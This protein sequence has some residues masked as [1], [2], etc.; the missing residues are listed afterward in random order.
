MNRYA[1]DK[2]MQLLFQLMD[3]WSCDRASRDYRQK[4]PEDLLNDNENGET[5]NGQIWFSAECLAS[6]S[7]IMDHEEESNM[8]RP[9]AKV[10]TNH[11]DQ[12]RILL[13]QASSTVQ[14]K[15]AFYLDLI[16]R[17]EHFDR[18]FTAFEFE[19]VKAMLPIKTVDDIERQQDLTVLFSEALAKAIRR[20]LIRQSHVDECNPSVMIS[21]PRL[22]IVHGLVYC[23]NSSTILKR[24]KHQL[25]TVLRAYHNLLHRIRHM[26]MS[27]SPAQVLLLERMLANEENVDNVDFSQFEKSSGLKDKSVALK[28]DVE[29]LETNRIVGNPLLTNDRVRSDVNRR[30]SAPNSFENDH[31]VTVDENRDCDEVDVSFWRRKKYKLKN[32]QSSDCLVSKEFDE[33]NQATP[34]SYRQMNESPTTDRHSETQTTR[35]VEMQ[36][37]QS[38]YGRVYEDGDHFADDED[39]DEYEQDSILSEDEDEDDDEFG[40]DEGL[41][42]S[43]NHFDH[44]KSIENEAR[45]DAAKIKTKVEPIVPEKFSVTISNILPAAVSKQLLHKLFVSIASIADQLQS[46]YASDLRA[47]L[48]TVFELHS[49]ATSDETDSFSVEEAVEAVEDLTLRPIVP[50]P[51]PIRE[52][53]PSTSNEANDYGDLLSNNEHMQLLFTTTLNAL[54]NIQPAIGCDQASDSS[55]PVESKR[56]FSRDGEFRDESIERTLMT[57][58]L[59]HHS[60]ARHSLNH[61]STSLSNDVSWPRANIETNRPTINLTSELS[62]SP[63]TQ[64]TQSPTQLP[65]QPPTQP[66]QRLFDAEERS[67]AANLPPIWVPDELVSECSGC[68]IQFTLLRRRHHCRNCGFIFCNNCS[69]HFVHLSHF[70][71][72]KPVRVCNECYES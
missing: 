1:Q 58:H 31:A 43:S 10:L 14:N 38:Y 25:P 29:P 30:H 5:F 16:A 69:N 49:S 39:S 36:S 17:L 44:S 28:C 56:K 66:P 61:D 6:G 23:G 13:R 12:I 48:K 62:S 2:V 26:L 41:R 7:D 72:S 50:K 65:T 42:A 45:A 34:E 11:L 52:N 37:E 24:Y 35:P 57:D 67:L 63:L 46:N 70:G 55:D 27:L 32:S 8:L 54:D 40:L 59:N 15:I 51:L 19:Y 60:Q 9:L 33:S 22:A 68:S 20:Q 64:S 21:L 71:Y 53:V 18:L 3:E 4:F 47:I